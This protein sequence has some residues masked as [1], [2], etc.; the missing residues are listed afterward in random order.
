MTKISLTIKS[1]DNKFFFEQ[2][3]SLTDSSFII[4]YFASKENSSN[5][6]LGIQPSKP[7]IVVNDTK[8][9]LSQLEKYQP[10]S[11]VEKFVVFAEYLTI[12]KSE[13]PFSEVELK[14][15][16]I[17][18]NFKV[19]ENFKRDLGIAVARGVLFKLKDQDLFIA[20][21]K[22]KKELDL[23]IEK[24]SIDEST[25]F[26]KKKRIRGLTQ[27]AELNS[28]IKSI[29]LTG[30]LKGLNIKYKDLRSG[31]DRILWVI[32]YLKNNAMESV[33]IKDIEFISNKLGNVVKSK[34]FAMYNKSNIENGYVAKVDNKFIITE[35]GESYI[36]SLSV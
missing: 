36:S 3:I 16:F 34:Y 10:K 32:T 33:S 29:P 19:P 9:L 23:M 12:V 11:N 35:E 14:E 6:S 8:L 7:Q 30:N 13:Q 2:E 27:R 5:T 28:D 26:K 21:P 4:N 31:S 25:I 1:E 18:A 20:T 24:Q 17:T 15:L 22:T